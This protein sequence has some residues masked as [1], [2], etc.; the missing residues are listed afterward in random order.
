MNVLAARSNTLPEWPPRQ[1]VVTARQGRCYWL[2]RGP[3]P[4]HGLGAWSR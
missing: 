2:Y 1:G 4:A 3:N